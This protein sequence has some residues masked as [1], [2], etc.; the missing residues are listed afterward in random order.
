[1]RELE[2]GMGARELAEWVAV[3]RIERREAD[4]AQ[5]RRSLEDGV[6]SNLSRKRRR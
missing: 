4:E 2:T 1:M 3:L 6:R 5:R